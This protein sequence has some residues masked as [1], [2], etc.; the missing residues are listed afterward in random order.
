MIGDVRR[1]DS[2]EQDG[3]ELAELVGAVGRHHHAMVPVIIRT[4]VEVPEIQGEPAVA[5]GADPQNLNASL[6]HFGPDAIT[7]HS[8]N[9]VRTHVAVSARRVI[10]PRTRHFLTLTYSTTESTSP[11]TS[12]AGS[13]ATLPQVLR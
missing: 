7:A 2:A 5:L 6:D 4:P 13:A 12:C 1:T 10:D 8:G 9:L 3:V 11:T